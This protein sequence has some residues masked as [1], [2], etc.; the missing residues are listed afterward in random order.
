MHRTSAASWLLGFFLLSAMSMIEMR[1]LGAVGLD[2]AENKDTEEKDT[3]K[4]DTEKKKADENIDRAIDRG[5]R[6]LKTAISKQQIPK[7]QYGQA[8]LETFALVVAGVPLDDRLVRSNYDL[9]AKRMRKSQHTYSL[10]CY[11][12][13]LDAAIGQ[14]ERDYL[15]LNPENADKLREGKKRLGGRFRRELESATRQLIFTQNAQGAWRYFKTPDFDN[16]NTQFAVLGLG[17]GAKRGVPVPIAVWRGIADHFVGGQ[18]QKG[19]VTSQRITLLPESE[20]ETVRIAGNSRNRAKKKSSSRSG[21]RRGRDDK[22]GGGTAVD[23]PDASDPRPAPDENPVVGLEEVPVHRRGWDY[24]NKGGATWNMT[25]AG[26]SSLL[27]AR[28]HLRGEQDDAAAD[29]LNKAIRDG[30]GWLLEDWKATESFYGMYS[31]EKVG[32]LGGVRLFGDRDWY[33]QLSAHLVGSQQEDGS[34]KGTGQHQEDD[35]IATALALLILRRATTL[36]ASDP[37]AGI[38]QTG[39]GASR[40]DEVK[41]DRDWIYVESLDCRLHYPSVLTA[42]RKR[43]EPKLLRILEKMV[44][45]AED[46]VR[47]AMVPDLVSTREQV[48]N[49][50]L[51]RGIDKL[52]T[53]IVGKSLRAPDEYARWSTQWTLIGTMVAARSQSDT[54][55]LIEL[56]RDDLGSLPLRKRAAWGLGR[57]KVR[58]AIPV[59][60]DDL[61][62]EEATHRELAYTT[63]REFYIARPPPFVAK[64]SG[65]ARTESIEAIRNWVER[66][67]A[68]L[69]GD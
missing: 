53:R 63:L 20:R 49:R 50:S 13:A 41:K 47:A 57:L 7:H 31:L 34:W 6:W 30:Y 54:K 5:V 23:E 1:S 32:D 43:S 8:S 9:L 68:R 51:K 62:A 37:G 21:S 24:E 61:D 22:R 56:Y 59:L 69:G 10:G 64:A 39:R 18:Q 40:G 45:E 52:L 27:I 12:F 28:E 55:R 58:S 4:K 17:V 35:R 38:V 16:S 25:C 11:I 46:D 66:Q 44:R 2:D 26:L 29:K 15:L 42:L 36:I 60:L 65:A 48:R 67:E 19:P 14:L 33:Q 3:E